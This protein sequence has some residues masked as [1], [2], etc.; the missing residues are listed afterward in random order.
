LAV[1]EG[2]KVGEAL[3]LEVLRGEESLKLPI[4]PAPLPEAAAQG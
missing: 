2:S 3:D 4:R 1:V